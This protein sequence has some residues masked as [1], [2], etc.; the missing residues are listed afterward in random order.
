MLLTYVPKCLK[1][2]IMKMSLALFVLLALGANAA[3]VG[4]A[5]KPLVIAV[6]D[7]GFGYNDRGHSAH[8]CNYGHKD[9]TIDRQ[10]TKNYATVDPIPVDMAG[11]GT[12]VVGLIEREI[13]GHVNYC[14]VIVKYYSEQ[15]SG[16]ENLIAS[17]KAIQYVAN[18]RADLINYSGGGPV[19]NPVEK[20]EVKRFLANGGK[21][22]AAAGN[23][24]QNLDDKKNSYYPAEY[25][26]RIVVV[27]NVDDQGKRVESSN[28]GKRVNRLENGL[29]QEAYNIKMTG[30][31]QATAVAT[32]KIA[33]ELLNAR[34]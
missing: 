9:F 11:H 26:A 23:E 16:H 34:K 8:L 1:F 28:Y 21:I 13:V 29:E 14:I 17:T 2:L 30:T 33:Q 4:A 24:N 22:I 32:G 19:S 3:N 27:G 20:K 7:A 5:S 31:S 12:N 6:V 15:Q 10:F 18:I 25:D